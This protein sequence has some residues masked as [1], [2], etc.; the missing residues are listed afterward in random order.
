ML[1]LIVHYCRNTAQVGKGGQGLILHLIPGAG[2][3]IGH[4]EILRETEQE[5]V[6]TGADGKS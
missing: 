3:A 6:S 1:G 2:Q 5:R 4:G